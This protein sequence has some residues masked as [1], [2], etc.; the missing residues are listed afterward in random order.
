MENFENL[1]KFAKK[2]HLEV[3]SDHSTKGRL[4]GRL[5][6]YIT[7]DIGEYMESSDVSVTGAET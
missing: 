1:I 4:L 7:T 3:D 6:P 2:N 5:R